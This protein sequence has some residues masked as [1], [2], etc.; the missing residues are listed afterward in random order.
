MWPRIAATI[1]L[2]DAHRF[3]A[4]NCPGLRFVGGPYSKKG[5]SLSRLRLVAVQDQVCDQQLQTVRVD[6]D[7]AS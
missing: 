5:Q 6:R 1:P 2:G 4:A 3:A 7:R